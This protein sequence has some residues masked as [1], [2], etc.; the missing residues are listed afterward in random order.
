MMFVNRVQNKLECIYDEVTYWKAEGGFIYFEV[1]NRGIE[2]EVKVEIENED[3]DWWVWEDL[4]MNGN[5]V[6]K[7]VITL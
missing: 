4:E 5:W 6:R 1:E 3:H 2:F 7:D